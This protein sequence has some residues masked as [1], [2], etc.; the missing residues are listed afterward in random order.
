MTT[1][2]YENGLFIF[3]RDYRIRD[4]NGLNR[5]NS[6][7]KNLYTIFIF[8]PE[9]VG[10]ENSFKSNNAVQFMIESLID[11]KQQIET[12]GGHLY[13]FYGDNIKILTEV[14]REYKIDVVG[15]NCDYTPYSVKRDKSI[16]ELCNK[17]EVPV[18]ISHD[19]YLSQPKTVVNQSGNPYQ[20]F[21][22]YYNAV[23]KHDF[24]QPASMK[25]LHFT[26]KRM[27]SSKL[28]LLQDAMKKFTK[29]N[30]NILVR[31]G[32]TAGLKKLLGATRT[33]TKYKTNHDDLS[34]STSGLSAY[35][36]F[37]CVSI[38]EVYKMLH[39]NHDLVRQLIWRDFYAQIMYCFPKVLGH[40][41]KP[42][43]DM[44]QWSNNAKFFNAWKNGLT[45][46]PIVDAGMRELN[47]TGY[48]HN[49]ARLI[50]ASFL[51]KTLLIDW[52]HGEKYFATKL[53]DYDVASN[54][55]N[56]QWVMGGGADSQPY[57]RIFNPWAQSAEHDKD[58]I[59]I[60]KWV[61][62]LAA[63][64]SKDIHNW[65]KRTK[66]EDVDYPDPIVDYVEQ[67]KKVLAMYKKYF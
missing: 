20:K 55:G 38:R 50:V 66:Y 59:Y 46:F 32:R 65:F 4:N 48:M 17:M 64:E 61:P 33:Q 29:I 21:T 37:G 2:V 16:V 44:I 10:D 8:T 53:T 42:T 7:C 35:I 3:R 43:Y 52:R 27:N 51:I 58:A 23:M 49:R 63:V 54:N 1:K 12:N 6:A 19:Y 15:F 9:Q 62:E 31:G 41:L 26:G 24:Q 40:A 28:I 57:F 18:L 67:K 34:V 11:L 30:E 36:K 39:G 60:K 13:S 45:G 25:K 14:I 22:P 56:W 47:T 5:I